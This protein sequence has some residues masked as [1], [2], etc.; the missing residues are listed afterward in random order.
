MIKIPASDS[1]NH[2]QS[3]AFHKTLS[4]LISHHNGWCEIVSLFNRNEILNEKYNEVMTDMLT[5]SNCGIATA[6]VVAIEELI[7]ELSDLRSE[8]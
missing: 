4:E 7:E 8:S 2:L 5:A 6:M 3:E 1:K